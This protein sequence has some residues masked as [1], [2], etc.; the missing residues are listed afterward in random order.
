MDE[1]Q[2]YDIEHDLYDTAGT[3]MMDL[4]VR[5]PRRTPATYRA[6][7]SHTRHRASSSMTT[8]SRD[9]GH[10]RERNRDGRSSESRYREREVHIKR[11]VQ[12]D[13]KERRD[14]RRLPG[15]SSGSP[16]A[17]S[18]PPNARRNGRAKSYY[19]LD[20]STSNTTVSFFQKP[21]SGALLRPYRLPLGPSLGL[22]A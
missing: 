11:D 1:S 3:P 19:R 18:S 22:W 6:S 5:P 4:S 15:V 13:R 16:I 20:R 14:S 8:D 21:V 7:S 9:R 17:A 2:A 10:E 12:D